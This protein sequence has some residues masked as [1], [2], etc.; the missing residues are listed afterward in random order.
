[1][2]FVYGPTRCEQR[3]KHAYAH[4]KIIEREWEREKMK[5]KRDRE[6]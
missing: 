3:D 5:E 4:E 6:E 2:T 1:M